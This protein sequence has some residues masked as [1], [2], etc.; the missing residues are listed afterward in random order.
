MKRAI[1]SPML[2]GWPVFS[3]MA[4]VLCGVL[5]LPLAAEQAGTATVPLQ[6]HVVKSLANTPPIPHA[7]QMD[8]GPITLT[9]VLAL[10]DAAGAKALE[11]G[12]ADPNSPDFRKTIRPAEFRARFGPS[13][14][15]YDAVLGY[16]KENGF[17]LSLGSISRRTITVRGT[18]AQAQ[19]AFNVA[20]DD[21]MVG[22]RTVHAVASDPSLPAKI[23]PLVQSVFGLSNLSPMQPGFTILDPLTPMSAATAYDGSLTPAGKTNSG[24]LPPGLDGSGQTIGLIEED[25]FKYSDVE[26]WLK[27]A[28]LPANSINNL[29]V[30]SLVGGASP[31]GCVETDPGCGTTEALLD[32]EAA[33]GIA[34][35]AKVVV[36]SVPAG[37]DPAA[38]IGAAGDYLAALSPPGIL[39]TSW[40]KCEGSIGQSDATGVDSIIAGLTLSGVSTFVFTGDH[41]A[42]CVDGSGTYTNGIYFPADAPHAIAVG[43]TYLEVNKDNTYFA[44][45]W[46]HG[47]GFGVSDLLPEPSYQEKEKPGASGRSVPDVAMYAAPGILVCQAESGSKHCSS[48]EAWEVG[49]TS[50]ATPLWAATWALAN[51]AADDAGP[52][53]ASA[54]NG[55]LYNY[56]SGFHNAG[57]MLKPGNNFGHVG[58]GSP[59]I[60]K[61]I[62]TV[63]PIE[64]DSFN[65]PGG[66]AIGNTK[67]TI[68]G[69][70][71]IGIKKV[72]F[73][74]VKG[75][76]LSIESDTKLTVDS[77]QA[78]G[79]QAPIEIE[80]DAGKATAS[81]NFLY[82]PQ[83]D[84]INPNSGPMEGRAAITVKGYGL[85][86]S[87][88][89]LFAGA[90]ANSVVCHSATKCTMVT[91]ANLPGQKWVEAQTT[92]GGDSA[93]NANT[94][95]FYDPLA[96]NSFS[97]AI[98]PTQGGETVFVYGH[99]FENGKT[100]FSFGGANAT[101][102]FCVD[103]N[104]CYM[105][106][107]A[108]ALDAVTAGKVQITATVGS[109]TSAPAPH[110][111][112]FEVFPT[113]TGISP[114][115]AKGGTTVT[116]T[117]TGFSTTAGKTTFNFF[118]IN[119]DGNCT[120]AI[121]CTAKVPFSSA[122]STAVTVTVDGNTSLDW[123]DFYYPGK[124]PPP[125]CKPGTC[126]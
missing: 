81:G 33:M 121:Q 67:V 30:V 122:H 39:S 91:P 94:Q 36:F 52:G 125:G 64:I 20:I 90:P 40:G 119:V 97:P 46:E 17:S 45:D 24:G 48:T 37:T 101:D 107:P 15:A 106:S 124:P 62:G 115:P 47:G 27:F 120:S 117:G 16:L 82:T 86:T 44:E 118:G 61:L 83:I 50:L 110:E 6:G 56:T 68:T 34:Q 14:E 93:I 100:V 123:V 75:T 60:A 109:D 78:P 63:V 103:P 23:A 114:D 73:G 69:T 71:F 102:V 66:P 8:N 59:D 19:K 22:D 13:Q 72:T 28:R 88:E 84:S 3:L 105:T 80:T 4:F 18:R 21:Y 126:S 1:A 112:K 11:D 35:G 38:S 111:F 51:Q 74:G 77:P 9:V 7:P 54:G 49:G 31:S 113:I 108:V 89:F 98:G 12:I 43:G 26:N 58:L 55:F 96:I 76:N 57:S 104:Y 10:S 85:D 29:S 65:P 41:G 25:T 99:S 2:T 70:G 32:I 92:W 5:I 79:D 53:V 42:D 116:L 87:E 95:F